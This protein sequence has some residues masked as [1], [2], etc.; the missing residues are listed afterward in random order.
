MFIP[1]PE[2]YPSRISDPGSKTATKERGEKKFVV[3]A[4]K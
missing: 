1:D 4:F 2:F 3:I